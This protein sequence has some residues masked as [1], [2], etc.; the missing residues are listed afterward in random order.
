MTSASPARRE[1]RP[2]SGP[3]RSTTR[4]VVGDRLDP[5]SF[6]PP[7]N[8]SPPSNPTPVP[9][10]CADRLRAARVLGRVS[11]V[12]ARSSPYVARSRRSEGAG[13]TASRDSDRHVTSPRRCCRAP[14]RRSRSGAPATPF[15]CSWQ[16]GRPWIRTQNLQLRV[17]CLPLSEA[18]VVTAN[19]VGGGSSAETDD[20]P[21]VVAR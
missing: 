10:R 20:P 9:R 16:L 8:A 2:K 5:P 11:G 3:A 7:T 21:T 1:H 13:R 12:V 17:C 18:R 15:S 14:R 6:H 4:R 19:V